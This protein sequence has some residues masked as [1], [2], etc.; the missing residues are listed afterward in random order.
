MSEHGTI[1]EFIIFSNEFRTFVYVIPM[2]SRL[3][4]TVALVTAY[5]ILPLIFLQFSKSIELI[6]HIVSPLT[7]TTI[8]LTIKQGRR[9]NKTKQKNGWKKER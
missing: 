8:R 1:C 4:H 5:T 3:H 2:G 7:K 6:C 9:Y